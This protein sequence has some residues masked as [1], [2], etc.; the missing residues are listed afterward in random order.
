M[1]YSLCIT[2]QNHS[3]WDFSAAHSGVQQRRQALQSFA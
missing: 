3:P 1:G 2:D